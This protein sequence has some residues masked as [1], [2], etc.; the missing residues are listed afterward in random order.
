MGGA[1]KF[2]H[3][4]DSILIRRH[5]LLLV[6]W[7]FL[8]GRSVTR[9]ILQL[10]RD[11]DASPLE[12][13]VEYGLPRDDIKMF[14][15]EI[16]EARD[17]GFFLLAGFGQKR[18]TRALLRWEV[19]E[20]EVLETPLE[21]RNSEK[22]K[23]IN[24][25]KRYSLLFW[26]G[27][28]LIRSAGLIAV[29]QKTRT[30]LSAKP[31]PIRVS[32][33]NSLSAKLK[34]RPLT[35][36]V[37]HDMGGGANIFRNNYSAK[38]I[39]EDQI[40]ILLGFHIATLQYFLEVIDSSSSCR[41]QI[42]SVH[43]LLTVASHGVVRN[44]VY[45]CAVSF[46]EPLALIDVLLEL[47]RNPNCVFFVLIHDYFI[48][49]P[50][51]FLINSSGQ[52]CGVP[53]EQC[54]EGCLSQHKD[55]LVSITGV[56]NIAHWRKKWS[57]LLMVADEVRLFSESSRKLLKRAFPL[58]SDNTW[59]V[60]PHDLHTEVPKLDIT[61][62]RFLHIGI[63]GAI[64]KYKGA[65]IVKDIASEIAARNLE[66]RITVIGTI[67]VKVPN[68]IVTIT[69]RYGPRQLPELIKSSGANVFLF[70]SLVAETFSYVSHELVSMGVLFACFDL[71]AQAD[72]ARRY[73][74]GLILK[75]T[76]AKDILDELDNF[77]R[78]SFLVEGV[79]A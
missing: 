11:N 2:H 69:G 65:Q 54:C 77:W 47:K 52:F 73:E 20:K 8:E 12:L 3:N 14:F 9:L 31:K 79:K 22:G 48:V 21:F 6:G 72:L 59:C 55:G 32:Q 4:I 62:G 44:I 45:N 42:E 13:Q 74:K 1:L 15:S 10:S 7:G 61:P 23:P 35:I 27:L 66:V 33:W 78:T 70:P 40:V 24:V 34:G 26:K 29:A 18:I 28:K 67:D 57:S 17:S 50:S 19:D 76:G 60:I 36:V 43:S 16:P 30:Y 5:T 49:C 39:A 63:V 37:D 75:S 41:Y 51:Y 58:L 53:D 68:N 38:Q 56:G 71:G 64:G 46:P 25:I